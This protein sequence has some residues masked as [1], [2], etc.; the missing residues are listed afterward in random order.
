M[1][2]VFTTCPDRRVLA[3]IAGSE[4]VIQIVGADL[5]PIA[6]IKVG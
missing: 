4:S 2:A 1:P 3:Y 6:K 5:Q